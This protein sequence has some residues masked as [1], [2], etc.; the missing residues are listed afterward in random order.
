M[1]GLVG[2]NRLN[3]RRRVCHARR[4][5]VQWSGKCNVTFRGERSPLFEQQNAFEGTDLCFGSTAFVLSGDDLVAWVRI[6]GGQSSL[7]GRDAT[8]P[9]CPRP[10]WLLACAPNNR[11]IDDTTRRFW[12]RPVFCLPITRLGVRLPLFAAA[13]G[14]CC[15]TSRR[16]SLPRC[17]RPG[18]LGCTCHPQHG[19]QGK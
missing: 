13:A 10:G 8:G 6:A 4:L 7:A 1:R 3:P 5:A 17:Q 15:I 16:T 12:S 2:R 11:Q 18:R 14:R 19:R 9:E